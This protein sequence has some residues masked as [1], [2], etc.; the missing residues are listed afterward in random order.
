MSGEAG[1]WHS[2]T[3]ASSAEL[4][5]HDHCLDAGCVRFSDDAGIGA[6]VFPPDVKYCSAATLMECVQ[7][8]HVTSV[9]NP[10]LTP[11]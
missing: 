5:L 2:D 11:V 6:M 8:L 4:I 1:V 3:V 7:G 10:S 9:S